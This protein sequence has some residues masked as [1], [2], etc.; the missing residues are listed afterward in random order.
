MID[1][2]T[3]AT[4]P[5]FGGFVPKFGTAISDFGGLVRESGRA[6]GGYTPPKP[7]QYLDLFFYFRLVC[8]KVLRCIKLT[9]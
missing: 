7:L 9:H 1:P 8:H 5:N 3:L 6:S 4:H 2:R